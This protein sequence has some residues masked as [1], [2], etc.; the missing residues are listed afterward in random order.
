MGEG[1]VRGSGGRGMIKRTIE[2]STRGTFLSVADGQLVISNG[3]DVLQ[4]T[5]I[6]DIGVM[7]LSSTAATYT[8]SV[9]TRLLSNGAI[10]VACGDDHLPCG[11]LLPQDNSLQTQRLADQLAV[12][13][14]VHKRLWRQIVV[15]KITNQAM[16]L[17]HSFPDFKFMLGLR[18]RVRSGDPTNIEAQAAKR[19]WAALFRNPSPSTGEGRGEGDSPSSVGGGS[20][21]GDFRFRRDR[22]GEPPTNFLNY[23]YMAL[24]AAVARAVAGAGLHPSIGIH[25]HN[26]CNGFCLADDLMEPLRPLVDVRVRRLWD[27]GRIIL[28]A[29]AKRELLGVLTATVKLGDETGPLMVALERYVASLVRCYA[30]QADR[31]EIPTL[32]ISADTGSCG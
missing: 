18:T 11:L 1:R 30:R 20:G 8:H 29:D 17:D 15:A 4:R 22:D 32:C 21:R 14:P 25:H 12:P 16:A 31:L 19:Y 24:R 13:R 28:D 7:L 6:E 26:R 10:I 27:A 23:G 2:I 3:G 5:P 9:I